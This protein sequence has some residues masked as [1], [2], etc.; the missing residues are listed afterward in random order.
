MNY[1]RHSRDN[2]LVSVSGQHT[3]VATLC[4]GDQKAGDGW[5]RLPFE[6]LSR[7][8][9]DQLRCF[10]RYLKVWKNNVVETISLSP[11]IK[12]A[13]EFGGRSCG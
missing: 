13:V 10:S 4:C 7:L 2:S 8:S 3:F 9:A 1:F 6:P 5:L 12:L 11:N